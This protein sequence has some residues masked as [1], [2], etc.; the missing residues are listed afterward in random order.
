MTTTPRKAPK[1][2][3]LAS[4]VQKV[5]M[6]PPLPIAPPEG[7]QQQTAFGFQMADG[8]PP[9][10][11][12][13]LAEVLRWIESSK[14]LPRAAALERLCDAMP[15]NVLEWCYQLH[16]TE[17]AQPLPSDCM[18]G[19][20]TSAQIE[21]AMV[22]R[23]NTARDRAMRPN[24]VTTWGGIQHQMPTWRVAVGRIVTAPAEPTT[25][26]QP[27]LLKLIR[28][29]WKWAKLRRDSTCDVLDDPKA[30][31]PNSLAIRLDKAGELWGYGRAVQ[32]SAADG[33]PSTWPE[34]VA[35]R[36]RHP[37]VLWDD[38][39]RKLLATEKDARGKGAAAALAGDL[40]V[41]VTAVNA[42]LQRHRKRQS[43]STA[44]RVVSIGK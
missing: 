11:L 4:A 33:Q 16:Q 25:P 3:A 34:L 15:V 8:K 18:F 38:N 26:G 43:A 30:A 7:W 1:G 37:G 35:Y 36:K 44:G 13:R 41:S 40:G 42:A 21:A 10:R 39:M 2:K 29:W 31:L 32:S 6:P 23:E 28:A 24:S 27:A 17:Y 20:Q 14:E 19:F 22:K 12:V 5:A 9:V